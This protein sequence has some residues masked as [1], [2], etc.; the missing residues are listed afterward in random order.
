M[1]MLDI[2][3]EAM[4]QVN[5]GLHNFMLRYKATSKLVYGFVEGKDD[6]MYYR[7]L[8]E[9]FIPEEWNVD[10]IRAGNKEKVSRCLHEL[11]W[12]R[13][14]EKRVCF[15]VDR[16]L[17]DLTGKVIVN[18]NNVY[19]TDGYSIENSIASK[20]M[21]IRLLSEV[22]NVIDLLPDEEKQ[23]CEAFEEDIAKFR[24]L[25]APVM[26][27]IVQWRR[28]KQIA[29]LDNINLDSLFTFSNGRLQL[30]S[31]CSG[32]M[33]RVASVANNL[34]VS[35]CNA[36]TLD[37]LKNEFASV[38][39][40]ENLVRGKYIFWFLS[41]FISSIWMS[42]G[43]YAA[44]YRSPPKIRVTIGPGNIHVYA[45][46]RARCPTSLRDFIENNYIAFIRG[47]EAPTMAGHH[48]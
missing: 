23:I 18:R 5:E 21:A 19:I 2:H 20:Y 32:E 15:F 39:G 31:Q 24:L 29:M 9:R 27:Q 34:N 44:A 3:A 16:D 28:D 40:V 1:S 12:T 47:L 25:L 8:I 38:G 17:D 48:T 26:A 36:Q 33:E 6:P 14:N 13:F 22:Y 42:I 43:T 37:A 30:H 46:P 35:C 10:L 11:D 7:S 4:Q 45:A 41:K